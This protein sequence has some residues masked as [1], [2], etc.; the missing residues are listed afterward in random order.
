M[1]DSHDCVQLDNL[2]RTHVEIFQDACVSKLHRNLFA[3]SG[4]NV[5]EFFLKCILSIYNNEILSKKNV[6]S[7]QHTIFKRHNYVENV[8]IS[9]SSDQRNDD[10]T[11]LNTSVLEKM[12]C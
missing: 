3:Q 7:A 4:D 12:K 6:D 2:I 8:C 1:L 10:I 11:I 9:L 5:F